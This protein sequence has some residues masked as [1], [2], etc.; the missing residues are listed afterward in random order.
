M[1]ADGKSMRA[2][3][4]A[5]GEL[6]KATPLQ[7]AAAYAAIVNDGVYWAPTTAS[8]FAKRVP[9]RVL[10]FGHRAN[11]GRAAREEVYKRARIEGSL[12]VS[13]G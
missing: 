11:H 5:A 9:E 6:A 8:T 13:K 3:V 12:L 1:V 10:T 4:L 7:V 2:A